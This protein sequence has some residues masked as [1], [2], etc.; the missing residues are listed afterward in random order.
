MSKFDCQL[1]KL[2]KLDD[3]TAQKGRNRKSKSKAI[4]LDS[5]VILINVKT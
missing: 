3:W 2:L 5:N 1:L 4:I